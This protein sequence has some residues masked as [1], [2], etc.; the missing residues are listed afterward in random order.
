M[1]PMNSA[2]RARAVA[3][4][5]ETKGAL[6][7]STHGLTVAQW[8]HKPSPEEWSIGDCVE[9]L[10][11]T[12]ASLLLTIQ[13]MESV[14][15]APEDQ[16]ALAAGKE[17]LIAKAVPSRGRRVKGPPEVMPKGEWSDPGTLLARFVDVRESVIGYVET[18]GDPIRTRQ[19]PHFFFGPLDGFQW[20]IFIAAHSERHR[21]QLEEVKT[22]AGFPANEIG[23][24]AR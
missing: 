7:D 5:K 18:T 3:Y 13:R 9:H 12:E 2:E 8:R 14:P 19:F 23:A 16:I 6:I 20:L 21:L 22:S 1:V 4:L 10:C 15:P 11:I 17:D 24:D